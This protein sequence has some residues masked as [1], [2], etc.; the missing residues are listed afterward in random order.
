MVTKTLGHV[1]VI[2]G[3]GFL[4][5]NIVKLILERFPDS[6]IAVLDVRTNVNRLEN[7]KVSYHDSDITN[8]EALEQLFAELKL[9][10]VIHTAA[11]LPTTL[12][13]DTISY[14]VNVDGTKNLLAVSKN[15]GVKAFIY[16]SSASVVVGDVTDIINVDESWP[17]LT[18]NEQ[19][20]YYSR[21]K[22][23]A[24]H[25]MA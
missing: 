18:G 20:E 1:A 21:T 9:D 5:F 4:G 12:I 22:V 13:A 10:T 11:I 2:G 24:E 17:I 14:K 25:I 3:C 23:G 8:L 19:P 6:R 7:K 16:T 15:N